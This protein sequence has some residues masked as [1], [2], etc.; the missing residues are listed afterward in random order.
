MEK[1]LRKPRHGLDLALLM[2]RNTQEMDRF[3]SIHNLVRDVKLILVLPN[4]DS[5]M[6]AWAHR[7]GP[8]FI[9]YTDNGCDQVGAVLEKMMAAARKNVET[10]SGQDRD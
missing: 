3:D 1:R 6:V 4:H 8:R 2:I 5:A 9:A 10:D 7:L